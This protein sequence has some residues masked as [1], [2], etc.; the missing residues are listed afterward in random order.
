MRAF[1]LINVIA[2]ATISVSAL[3]AADDPR[4]KQLMTGDEMPLSA[5]TRELKSIANSYRPKTEL[6]REDELKK[7]VEQVA[8]SLDSKVLKLTGQVKGIK[9]DDNVGTVSV[10]LTGHGDTG[11][12][13][14]YMVYGF[15]IKIDKEEAKKIRKGQK[16]ELRAV[17][18][19]QRGPWAYGPRAKSQQ[20]HT[21][22]AGTGLPIG[23]FMTQVYQI[24][25]NDKAYEGV[26]LAK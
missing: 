22:S 11:L 10:A 17:A 14:A 18:E 23:T 2:L 15:S 7:V 9:W 6:D 16:F 4:L 24:K 12:I 25:I 3:E 8:R 19:F 1:L 21:I 13:K 20:L 26:W 5:W